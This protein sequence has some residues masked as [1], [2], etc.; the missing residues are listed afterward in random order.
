L[1]RRAAIADR[2]SW[3]RIKTFDPAVL[4]AMKKME[5]ALDAMNVCAPTVHH[6]HKSSVVSY[7]K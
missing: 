7:Q 6:I 4:A 3:R 5:T 1:S 2:F